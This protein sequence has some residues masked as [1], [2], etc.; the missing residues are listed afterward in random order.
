LKTV[1][2]LQRQG[3]LPLNIALF[4]SYAKSEFP[5]NVR[6]VAIQ[7]LVKLGLFSSIKG[8]SNV[9]DYLFE[10]IEKENNQHTKYQIIKAVV[11]PHDKNSAIDDP[12]PRRRNFQ[13]FDQEYNTRFKSFDSNN[14][15]YTKYMDKVWNMLNTA[16]ALSDFRVRYTLIELYSKVGGNKIFRTRSTVENPQLQISKRDKVEGIRTIINRN[17]KPKEEKLHKTF[18]VNEIDKF[19]KFDKAKDEK[20]HKIPGKIEKDR[21]DKHKDDKIKKEKNIKENIREKDKLLYK[22]ENGTK[23][24][25]KGYNDVTSHNSKPSQKSLNSSTSVS[26]PKSLKN[27]RKSDKSDKSEKSKGKSRKDLKRKHSKS[28]KKKS[29]KSRKHSKEP[30]RKSSHKIEEPISTIKNIPNPQIEENEEIVDVEN[31]VT[32]LDN[33]NSIEES[34][35]LVDPLEESSESSLILFPNLKKIRLYLPNEEEQNHIHPRLVFANKEQINEK[36]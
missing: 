30:K 8:E 35:I 13:Y 25:S 22:K 26:P 33:N 18:K 2:H 29:K 17:D 31:P 27:S 24:G 9:I 1:C 32:S 6:I 19:K 10:L 14:P 21:K 34:I 36:I 4:T 12:V 28:P 11:Y 20:D 23:K 16:V 5:Q 3:W 15:K 7:S